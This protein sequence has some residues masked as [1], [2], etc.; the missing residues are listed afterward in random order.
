MSTSIYISVNVAQYSDGSC[1]KSTNEKYLSGRFFQSGPLY[2]LILENILSRMTQSIFLAC[3]SI[4]QTII[5]IEIAFNHACINI[6]QNTSSD[7]LT[8][9]AKSCRTV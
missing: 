5:P 3:S 9:D 8:G 2:L 1:R 7:F 6:G 4:S